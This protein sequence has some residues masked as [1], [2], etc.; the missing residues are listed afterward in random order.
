M[1]M[2][3]LAL[4]VLG[5]LVACG[6]EV[7]PG[8][9]MIYAAARTAPAKNE[10]G[11]AITDE[12]R[13]PVTVNFANAGMLAKQLSAG[14]E[15]DLFFSANEQWMNYAEKEGKIIPSTRRTILQDEL[16]LIVPKG[17]MLAVDFTQP[18]GAQE[19][20]GKFAVGE[21]S[22]PIGIYSR[23]AFTKLGWWEPLQPHLC[24]AD[25]VPKV[26]NYVLLG[27]ADVG[28]VFRSVASV[29][30]GK[31]DVV[32]TIPSALHDPVLFPIAACSL[33]NPATEAF[34][35]FITGPQAEA[36]FKKFGWTR[37]KGE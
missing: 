8:S 20:D 32:G 23:Q 27:E 4:C 29:A 28:V 15:A 35:S 19:F 26:L 6:K 13:L 14:G 34:L 12:T 3:G 10:L 24:T 2:S 17:Q 16:V 37:Y 36:A 31:V 18:K 21:S 30:A 7:A 5:W 1:K 22:T 33:A 11:A 25:V 9:L